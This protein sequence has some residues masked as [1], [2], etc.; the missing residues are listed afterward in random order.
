MPDPCVL[1]VGPDIATDTELIRELEKQATVL[2]TQ[3][4]LESAAIFKQ[5]HVDLLL[6]EVE[7]GE[8]F[9]WSLIKRV[10]KKAPDMA[11]IVINGDGNREV[12]ARAFTLGVTDAFAKPYDRA[13][14]VER[15]RALLRHR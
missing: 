15:V 6:L 5:R 10:M 4:Y 1:I 8:G 7:S 14:L 3:N 13:L 2:K 12:I 11:I 9:D